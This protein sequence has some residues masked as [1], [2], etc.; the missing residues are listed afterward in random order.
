[1]LK[2]KS[3]VAKLKKNEQTMAAPKK[4]PKGRKTRKTA[5]RKGCGR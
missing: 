4:K 5:K 1:M 3:P 2:L